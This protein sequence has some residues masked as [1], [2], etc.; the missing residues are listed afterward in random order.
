MYIYFCNHCN[1]Y[2][3]YR[4][5]KEIRIN[6]KRCLI[7]L[8]ETMQKIYCDNDVQLV[9]DERYKTL[10]PLICNY[11]LIDVIYYV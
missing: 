11:G 4:F 9:I 2:Y 7:C 10:K 1:L 6:L 5:L 3:N 8:L